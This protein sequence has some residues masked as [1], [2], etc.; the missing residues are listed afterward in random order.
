MKKT[1]FYS[2]IHQAVS[3]FTKF[4]KRVFIQELN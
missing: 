4:Y 2:R 1:D 3:F